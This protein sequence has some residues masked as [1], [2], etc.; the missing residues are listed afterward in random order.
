M[1]GGRR[2]SNGAEEGKLDRGGRGGAAKNIEKS[3]R[4][5]GYAG[6]GEQAGSLR[7]REDNI[8]GKRHGRGGS[9]AGDGGER[10]ALSGGGR[11]ESKRVRR[12]H[13][14]GGA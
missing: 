13:N 3:R 12:G 6:N 5:G 14:G 4:G 2:R 7:E 9:E 10:W 11:D 8:E 1:G